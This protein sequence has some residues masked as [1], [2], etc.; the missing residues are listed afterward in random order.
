MPDRQEEYI[1][2]IKF[3]YDEATMT[4]QV[5]K[6]NERKIG[7]CVQKGGAISPKIFKS[8]LDDI[9]RTHLRFSAAFKKIRKKC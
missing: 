4:V 2:L 6:G 5:F 3:L 7:R 8:A 9:F 1:K